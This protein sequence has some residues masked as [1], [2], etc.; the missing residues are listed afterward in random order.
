MGNASQMLG[1]VEQQCSTWAK[2]AAGTGSDDGAVLQFDGCRRQSG[3]LLAFTRSHCGAAI[4]GGEL[5]L[6]HQQANLLHLALALAALG[7]AV[8]C[9]VVAAD[10]LVAGSV[11]AHVLVAHAESNHVHTHIGGRLIRILAVH[12]LE[13]GIQHREDF[14]VAIVVHC[15]LSVSLKVERVNHVHVVKVG[16]SSFVSHIHRMLQRQVPYG[17]GLKL[18]ITGFHATLVLVI[19]LTKTHSHLATARTGCR[20]YNKLTRSLGKVV[21]TETLV[22]INQLNIV[23]IPIDGVV[24]AHL[25]AHTLEARTIGIGAFL[26]IVVSDNNIGGIQARF[27]KLATQAQ[28]IF[29]VGDAQ[30]ATHLVLFDVE[31]ANHNYHLSNVAQLHEH[32]QFA[33]GVETRQNAACVIIVKQLTSKLEV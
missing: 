16:C 27:L 30:V 23:W 5:G 22:G 13:D 33:V 32:S 7:K 1:S 19:E 31:S 3:E 15:N 20:D 11:A 10:N 28:H 12:A 2:Q 21:A 25:N 6:L 24:I 26:T 4:F 9:S 14:D 17:E 8:E 29:V 18:G